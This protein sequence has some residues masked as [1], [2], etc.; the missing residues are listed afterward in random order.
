MGVA[1]AALLFAYLDVASNPLQILANVAPE[2]VKIM[3]GIIVLSV[4]IAYEMVRRYGV[5]AEQRKVARQLG[6]HDERPARPG[7]AAQEVTA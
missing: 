6:D 4:V 3:Q 7:G 5:V 2:I 1:F